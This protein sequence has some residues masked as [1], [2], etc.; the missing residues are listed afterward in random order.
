[1]SFSEVYS[2]PNQRKTRPPYVQKR[3]KPRSSATISRL[4]LRWQ[5]HPWCFTANMSAETF[6]PLGSNLFLGQLRC[7]ESYFCRVV[8]ALQR[9]WCSRQSM[10]TASLVVCHSGE[11]ARQRVASF[12][13]CCSEMNELCVFVAAGSWCGWLELMTVC[14]EVCS[15]RSQALTCVVAVYSAQC[16]K[17]KLF[18]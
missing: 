18:V 16:N 11:A 17:Q 4:E 5:N 1:M 12:K 15:T 7:C 8:A 9:D 10:P 14:E 6:V 3:V 2:K 13:M